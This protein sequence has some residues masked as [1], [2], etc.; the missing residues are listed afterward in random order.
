MLGLKS[1][2]ETKLSDGCEEKL[3]SRRELWNMAQVS[4]D[5][6]G[7]N[8]LAR[9]INQSEHRGYLFFILFFIITIIFSLV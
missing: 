2:K 6:E 7:I 9:L 3:A 5:L 4:D 8:D 1:S